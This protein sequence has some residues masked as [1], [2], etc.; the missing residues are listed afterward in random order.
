MPYMGRWT[1]NK[2][3]L[4]EHISLVDSFSYFFKEQEK[5]TNTLSEMQQSWDYHQRLADAF[6]QQQPTVQPTTKFY[7][8]DETGVRARNINSL[9]F[10]N[11]YSSYLPPSQL[12]TFIKISWDVIEHVNSIIHKPTFDI[13]SC[14]ELLGATLV[15]VGMASQSNKKRSLEPIY[16]S[17]ADKSKEQ[18]RHRRQTHS[19]SENLE[20]YQILV[21]LA[22]YNYSLVFNADYEKQIDL[23]DVR[24]DLENYMMIGGELHDKARSEHN[25]GNALVNPDGYSFYIGADPREQWLTWVRHESLVRLG[26][27]AKLTNTTQMFACQ[28]PGFPYESLSISEYD[29]VMSSAPALWNSTSPEMFF[30]A[31]GNT[32]SIPTFQFLLILK[33]ML[34]LPSLSADG[35]RR[36]DMSMIAGD[37]GWSLHHMYTIL[38]GL[39]LVGWIVEGCRFYQQMY[40]QQKLHEYTS[41]PTPESLNKDDLNACHTISSIGGSSMF[42]D[43]QIKSRI[44]FSF[45][46]FAEFC[47]AA[48]FEHLNLGFSEPPSKEMPTFVWGGSSTVC[49]WDC[50][51]GVSL[52]FQTAYFSIYYNEDAFEHKLM[53]TISENLGLLARDPQYSLAMKEWTPSQVETFL[54]FRTLMPTAQQIRLLREWASKDATYHRVFYATYYLLNLLRSSTP[55]RYGG[56]EIVFARSLLLPNSLLI[57]A[58]DFQQRYTANATYANNIQHTQYY[59]M[60]LQNP[61]QVDPTQILAQHFALTQSVWRR[62]RGQYVNPYEEELTGLNSLLKRHSRVGPLEQETSPQPHSLD[63]Q[64]HRRTNSDP[65]DPAYAM[66]DNSAAAGALRRNTS[67]NTFTNRDPFYNTSNNA[68]AFVPQCNILSWF[69]LLAWLDEVK[70]KLDFHTPQNDILNK[71]KA[72]L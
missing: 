63:Y 50:F 2:R 33:C 34:R 42:A 9:L 71:A 19:L 58:F 47:E 10:C 66:N 11:D 45:R 59:R 36:D 22:F 51:N 54:M 37:S 1:T 6:L 65:A 8:L 21:L 57:W 46:V 12:S 18:L 32:R 13:N 67:T 64:Q 69:G 31:V 43:K 60:C 41:M 4:Q 16:N 52:H 35:E 39:T 29:Y 53:E 15:Y 5:D 61:H 24:L 26:H 30:H 55:T 38:L 7:K 70:L 44:F 20:S 28:H 56:A 23:T 68:D 72:V 27:F 14:D 62:T 25:L 49:P 48:S 40:K 3:S 17:L